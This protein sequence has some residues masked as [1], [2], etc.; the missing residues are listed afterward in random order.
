MELSPLRG[1][2]PCMHKDLDLSTELIEKVGH[3]EKLEANV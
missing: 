1:T 3:V 2:R